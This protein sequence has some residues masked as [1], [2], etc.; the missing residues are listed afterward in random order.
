MVNKGGPSSDKVSALNDLLKSSFPYIRVEEL[1]SIPL[2]A[3]AR[4]CVLHNKRVRAHQQTASKST[5]D[6]T[7]EGR[8]MASMRR[9][10]EKEDA[11]IRY[12]AKHIKEQRASASLYRVQPLKIQIK[13]TRDGEDEVAGI[14]RSRE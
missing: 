11:L 4:L 9:R 2:N 14:T 13:T 1:R 10:K 5:R 8:S 12:D 6:V 3:L 7:R